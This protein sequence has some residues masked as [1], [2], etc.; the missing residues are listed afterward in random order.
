MPDTPSTIPRAPK[1]QSTTPTATA[2]IAELRS[3]PVAQVDAAVAASVAAYRSGDRRDMTTAL[4]EQVELL[5]AL[6]VTLIRRAGSAQADAQILVFASLA[7]K[8]FESARRTMET[9]GRLLPAP[10]PTPSGAPQPI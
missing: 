5:Q 7:L 10:T 6:G 2:T 1:E 4:T 9:L 3:L 8:A